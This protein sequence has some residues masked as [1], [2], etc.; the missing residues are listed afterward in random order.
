MPLFVEAKLK[1]GDYFCVRSINVLPSP[2]PFVDPVGADIPTYHSTISF[3][4]PNPA[5]EMF[6]MIH[7]QSNQ[8]WSPDWIAQ[9][10]QIKPINLDGLSDRQVIRSFIT[11]AFFFIYVIYALWISWS[12]RFQ[13]VGQDL[14]KSWSLVAD[15]KH[16]WIFYILDGTGEI[17]NSLKYYHK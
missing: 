17:N 6:E 15:I 5:H 14:I 2:R 4:L 13:G 1:S 3:F 7:G 11:Y 16:I 9:C 10:H 8:G 12:V